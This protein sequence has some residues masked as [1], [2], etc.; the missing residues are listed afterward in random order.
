VDFSCDGPV[1]WRGGYN[2]GRAESINNKFLNLECGINRVAVRSTL[3]PGDITVAATCPGLQP[4]SVL[5]ASHSFAISDGY[6]QVMPAMPL[7]ALSKTHPDWT[8]LA[9]AT[10]PMTVSSAPEYA[11]AGHRLID[12]FNYTGPTELVHVEV[13]ASDGKNVY[14]DRD[15]P[16]EN[17]PSKLTG[18]DWVQAADA[19]KF[20]PA[21]DLMQLAV[22]AGTTVYVAYDSTLPSPDWLQRQLQPTSSSLVIAGRP[23]KLF[24]R[25]LR[26]DE[27]LTFGSNAADAGKKPC[28]MYVVFVK[29][30]KPETTASR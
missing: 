26:A 18:A 20:Y 11:L 29:A 27:S 16:F 7:V 15:Y 6:S 2:S 23:M 5:I 21:A 10:P 8:A 22:K 30:G 25:H 3:T 28:N 24:V 12:M 17:L 13:G 1:I 19:D 14:C 4:A 9:S